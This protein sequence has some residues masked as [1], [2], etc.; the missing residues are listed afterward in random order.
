MC[1]SLYDDSICGMIHFDIRHQASLEMAIKLWLP[2]L[3]RRMR[4]RALSPSVL[5]PDPD[6]KAATGPRVMNQCLPCGSGRPEAVIALVGTTPNYMDSHEASGDVYDREATPP[7]P[8]AVGV[9]V[10]FPTVQ[11]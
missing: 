11:Q 4:R 5:P 2:E 6:D 8:T 10:G 7:M 9:A 3:R 1:G